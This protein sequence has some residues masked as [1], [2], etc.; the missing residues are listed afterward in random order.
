MFNHRPLL[1]YMIILTKILT[2]FI[3]SCSFNGENIIPREQF[4]VVLANLLVIERLPISEDEK[5]LLIKKTF[6]ENKV[7]IEQFYQTR[8]R[9]REDPD[10][11]ISVYEEA[12]NIFKL[13]AD[14]LA[15][16]VDD[17]QRSAPE[18]I[19]D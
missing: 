2:I 13:Q 15:K 3:S 7:T 5:L 17:M 18:E 14:S 4:V 8:E 16:K 6:E 11:W 1:I 19:P 12:K 10:Y 9:Y